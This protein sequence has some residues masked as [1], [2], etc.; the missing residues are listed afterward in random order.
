MHQSII[1]K[2]NLL[3]LDENTHT[4]T[5]KNSNIEFS[6]VTEFISSF[7]KPFNAEKIAEKLI[8]LPKHKGKTV[9]SILKEWDS[10]RDRGTIVHKEIEDFI[11]ITNE[12]NEAMTNKSINQLDL[13][14]Q[15][16][17]KFLKKCDI[18]KNNLIFPE[19]KVCA[20]KLK[21]AGTIDLMIYNKPNNTISL[22]D[23][24]TN[25][26]I[27]KESYRKGIKGPAMDINDC[28]FNRYTLQLSMYQYILET[29]YNATINGLYILHLKNDS[30][31][32][33]KCE[34]QN[35]HITNMLKYGSGN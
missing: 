32:H 10:R 3:S 9:T 26:A 29:F 24:K 28:S 1:K 18:Y 27:K 5:L 7:F 14:S 21:L 23:W 13:K 35:H 33:I 22:I 30:F 34:F 19:V 20:E 4:Y 12:N 16:A 15:Q 2:N 25:V 31:N 17:I 8:H 11:K 6:S